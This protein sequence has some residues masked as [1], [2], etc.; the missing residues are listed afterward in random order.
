MMAGT[1]KRDLMGPSI[2]ANRTT[3]RS[4]GGASAVLGLMSAAL[5]LA[6]FRWA[7]HWGLVSGAIVVAWA[8]AT[9]SALVLSVWSLH[10]RRSRRR[11]AFVGLALT[12]V[13][14]LAVTLV[15]ALYAAGTDVSSACGG[16]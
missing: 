7:H 14:V 5:L 12:F 13:S 6:S 11:L 16:G 3:R 9:I 4:A 2:V 10:A 15:G 8:L 1:R